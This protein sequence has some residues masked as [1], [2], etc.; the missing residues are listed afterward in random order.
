PGPPARRAV[1]AR[2]AG[3][4]AGGIIPR[5]AKTA[6]ALNAEETMPAY[7]NQSGDSPILWFD[8]ATDDGPVLAID[9]QFRPSRRRRRP[10]TYRYEGPIA[11]TLA[12]LA[13][14]GQ[15]LATHLAREKPRYAARWVG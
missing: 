2:S 11:A 12:E 5:F 6:T 9:I 10:I 13:R 14:A 7:A 4:G 15:G 1:V 3:G 8:V